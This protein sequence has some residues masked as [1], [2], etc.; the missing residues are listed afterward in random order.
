MSIVGRAAPPAFRRVAAAAD[1]DELLR[2]G[3]HVKLLVLR[4]SWCGACHRFFE[5][6]Q[7]VIDECTALAE[8]NS[9]ELKAVRERTTHMYEVDAVLF[10]KDKALEDAFWQV[11]TGTASPAEGWG[12]PTAV[13]LAGAPGRLRRC[14]SDYKPMKG[15]GETFSAKVMLQKFLKGAVPW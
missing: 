15:S 3:A 8:R 6:A 13:A 2:D 1:L 7:Q 11:A 4:A 9:Q 5:N 12:Y 10:E 14:V